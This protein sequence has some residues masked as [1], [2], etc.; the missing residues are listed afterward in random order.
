MVRGFFIPGKDMCRFY[1]EIKM[2]KHPWAALM[3]V[4]MILSLTGTVVAS[5]SKQTV[6]TIEDTVVT[7]TRS[8]EQI[9]TIP[10]K[11]EV[12]NAHEIELTCV[13]TLTE[14]LKKN[15]SIGVVEYGSDLAG[16]G[17]R[18][19]RPEF[20]GITKHSLIL[21]DGRPAGATNLATIL[22]DN[23][24]RI[25]I[26][27]G[28]ASSLY[29]A[30]AMGGV[31]NIITKKST[32]K[33]KGLVELG[34][35][36]H[37]TNFQKA[38]LGGSITSRMDFDVSVRRYDQV[39][40]FTMGNG[41]T[42]TNT[43][44]QTQNGSVRL[45]MDLGDTWR[46]DV[47]ADG[48]QGK[49]IETPGNV[50]NG[51]TQSGKKDMNR[52]GLDLSL[53]GE[54]GRHNQAYLTLYQTRE[55][56]ENFQNYTGY[57]PYTAAPTFQSYDSETSW[58]GFQLKDAVTWQAHKIILGMDYQE[59]DMESRSYNS[60]GTWKAP[61]SPDESRKNIAGYVETLL[62]FMDKRLTATLGGRYDTFDVATKSTPY[63]TDF[64]PGTE[65]FSFVSPRA[66][67]TYR[68]DKGVR[69]H[70]TV[71]Q[72][73]V[74]PTAG[75]LAGN[76]TGWGGSTT[77]GNPDLDP[78]SSITWDAGMGYDRPESGLSMDVT[79]F[80]TEIEDKI[81][82]E[83]TGLVTTYK[84]SLG[85]EIQGLEYLFSFDIGKPLKWNRSLSFF[86]NGTRIFSAVEEQSN[87]L[88]KDIYNVANHTVNYGIS[89]DDGRV[90]AK[91]NARYQGEMK[92]NDWN[93]AGYPEITCPDFTV[94]DLSAGF[95]F[96][97]HHK[98]IIKID[99]LLDEDYY[100][101]KGFPKPGQSFFVSYRY[102][103]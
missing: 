35:G 85:A 7:A 56:Q 94:V 47:R 34:L 51:D 86:V 97:D 42:R 58:I 43:S 38:A 64:T 28:P 49:D 1:K 20:S 32:G 87:H 67:I 12:I 11:V 68:F 52:W 57:G 101:K 50:F 75:Q 5:D 13:Q 65:S 23:I 24:E 59:I 103:F 22:S 100:E 15:A 19:F 79:Y 93:A 21:I 102:T 95:R 71:G 89:Y 98:I 17:I 78:E 60:D 82:T 69:L 48:Y 72:A 53:E 83:T 77:V 88:E 40:D 14:Q 62:S 6:T 96:M 33:L 36:S 73:F 99:N 44:F 90:E 41:D 31:V 4:M 70:A 16:I 74:P 81:I 3:V 27:K 84:N 76:N 46:A 91:L 54:I 26:L 80:S 55:L 10:A 29:G 66:G 45:G 2:K 25:E 39:N 18:G 92:D 8:E 61:W 9:S 63:K 37:A 30:E